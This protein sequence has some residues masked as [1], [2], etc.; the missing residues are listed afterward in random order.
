[1]NLN[2]SS[3]TEN[4]ENHYNETVPQRALEMEK[5]EK[6]LD[7]GKS[8]LLS[9]ED[10]SGK[11]TLLSALTT[12]L[13]NEG[14]QIEF[15]NHLDY[16][17]P[18]ELGRKLET[19]LEPAVRSNAKPNELPILLIDSIDYAWEKTDDERSNL[20]LRLASVINS[21]K[22]RC[23]MTMHSE[24]PK[25]KNVDYILKKQF[26]PQI[27]GDGIEKIELAPYYTQESAEDFLK[28]KGLPEKMINDLTKENTIGRSHV[29]L[30]NYI[31]TEEN[32][33]LLDLLKN[34]ANTYEAAVLENDTT[35]AEFINQRYEKNMKELLKIVYLKKAESDENFTH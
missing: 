29:H 20:R 8:V 25:G 21:E 5:I 7:A 11:T 13:K 12:K 18:Q 19:F 2:E 34:Y 17:S 32:A 24:E 15:I 30:T 33:G 6:V 23:V 9:G 10:G 4:T 16:R 27:S 14:T 26:L 1:M 35:K 22:F 31:F 28:A 3:S